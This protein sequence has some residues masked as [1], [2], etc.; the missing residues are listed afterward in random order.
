MSNFENST[1]GFTFLNASLAVFLAPLYERVPV[2]IRVQGR[3]LTDQKGRNVV[4][5]R[6]DDLLLPGR[7][8]RATLRVG[9]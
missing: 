2:E 4:S 1:D 7:N 5:F 6:A 9:F 8:V 3:N